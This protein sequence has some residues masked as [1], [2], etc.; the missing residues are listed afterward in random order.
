VGVLVLGVVVEDE[1]FTVGSETWISG[2]EGGGAGESGTRGSG[3][4]GV[5]RRRFLGGH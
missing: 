2:D 1:V 4:V 5:V 3:G